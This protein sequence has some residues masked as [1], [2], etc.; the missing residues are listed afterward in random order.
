MKISLITVCFNSIDTIKDTFESVAS[1]DY[2][3][4][5]YIVVD[6]QSNDGTLELLSEYQSLIDIM[7][8]EPD[9]GIYD[10]MN[11]GIKAATGDVIGFINADDILEN[12]TVI[13]EVAE[14]FANNSVDA[15]YAD[16]HYVRFDNMSTVVRNWSSSGFKPGAF[17]KGWTPPHPTFYVKKSVYETFGGFDL[18]YQMGND[19]ELML[20]FMEKYHIKTTYVPKVWV[21]MRVGG[22]S[23]QSISNI[24]LQNREIIRAAKV[25]QVPFSIP[26]FVLGKLKD[27]LIQYIFK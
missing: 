25:N 21:K 22:V 18:Q 15:C 4:L 24:I 5:E 1:Q 11:K 19:I 2:D 14:A 27:R 3:D 6:G 13:T 10:A 9:Q 12:S 8:S 26:L 7:I 20:R 17:S 16:L 23:N